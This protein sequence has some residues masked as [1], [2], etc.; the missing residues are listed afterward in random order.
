MK[1]SITKNIEWNSLE[2]E[3]AWIADMRGVPQDSIHHGEGDVSIHTRMVLDALQSLKDFQQLDE[4]SQS[5]MIAAALLHDVE[6]R[7]TTV[8]EENGRITS[9]GHAKRGEYTSRDILFR[10]IQTPFAIRERICALVRF[11]GLPLW[12]M[13]KTE[14]AKSAIETSLRIDM[15]LLSMLAKAD[16]FGRICPDK[17]EL[18]DRIE[19][20]DE[21][22]KEQLCW[23]N[24]REFET[25]LARFQYFNKENSPPDYVPFDN[26][27]AEVIMLCG[28]P[29]MGKD[30]LIRKRYSGLPV[31]SLDD[32][33]RKHKLKPDDKSSTGWAVQQAKEDAKSF[34]RKGESFIWNATNITRQMRRQWIDLFVTYNVRVKLVY[35]EVSYKEWIRQN[36]NRSYPVPDAVLMRMLRKL[37]VPTLAEAHEVEYVVE[38]KY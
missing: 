23:A 22:C 21:Y 1:W 31:V 11:H 24:P 17:N 12:I 36:S 2:K 7:S 29:G 4:Q 38:N 25:S 26:L 8:I 32:I 15:P 34:L 3:F 28:L 13:E 9:R 35:V 20:F 10:D 5:L 37:E 18:L 19:L 6:K 16:V 33:R 30:T 14:P 27:K